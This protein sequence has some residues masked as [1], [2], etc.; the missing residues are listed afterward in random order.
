MNQSDLPSASL[1]AA[2][3][4]PQ[5]PRV[6]LIQAS[7]HAEIVGQA[8]EGFLAELARLGCATDAVQ[9]FTVPGAFEIPL[10]AKKLAAS[11]RF[12]AIVAT[13]L[14]VDGGIYRHDF[15]ATAVIDGLMRVQLDTEVPV[16]SVV[17]TPHH[18]HEHE[19]HQRYFHT[20]FVTK[21]AE[22]A[23]A[24]VMTLASLQQV[25]AVTA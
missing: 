11:G 17:L 1:P 5:R 10:H 4:L 2:G 25:A 15:V 14:V 19:Q 16:F 6:A 20:H 8:R 9:V 13:G 23:R 7:W 22:A 12:D 18:F 21:G 3:A 24:C